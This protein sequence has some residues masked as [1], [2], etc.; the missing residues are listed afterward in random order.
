MWGELLPDGNGAIGG[1]VCGSSSAA[2]ASPPLAVSNIIIGFD[3]SRH[4]RDEHAKPVIDIGRYL[5]RDDLQS[6]R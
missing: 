6:G 4:R 2:A 1:G 3:S 5:R